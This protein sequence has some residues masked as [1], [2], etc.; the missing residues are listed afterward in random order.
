MSKIKREIEE[1]QSHSPD[2]KRRRENLSKARSSQQKHRNILG[3]D[4]SIGSRMQFN[5]YES[6]NTAIRSNQ[7]MRDTINHHDVDAYSSQISMGQSLTSKSMFKEIAKNSSRSQ[8]K[9]S[10]NYKPQESSQALIIQDTEGQPMANSKQRIFSAYQKR[11]N[12][13]IERNSNDQKIMRQ[14][15]GA[16]TIKKLQVD[17]RTRNTSYGGYSQIYDLLKDSCY[18]MKKSSA[19]VKIKF[20]DYCQKTCINRKIKLGDLGMGQNAATELSQII[21]VNQNIAH[22][23]LKKNLLGDEGVKILIK[24]ISKS[25]NIVHLD[26]SSNQ[27]THKGAKKI[28]T[29]LLPNCSLISLKLGSIDG[30]NKNK[31]GQKGVQHLIPLLQHSKFLQF[32]DLRSNI[33]SDNGIV[34]LCDA[35]FQNKTLVSLNLG[36]NEITSYGMERLKDALLTTVLNEL[37]LTGNPLGNQGI[38]YLGQYMSHADCN[39]VRLNISECRFQSPGSILLFQAVRKCSSLKH[40][41]L[42]KNDLKSRNSSYLTTGIYHGLT[43]LS[44]IRCNLG[45]DE[46]ISVAEGLSRSRQLKA[47]ILQYNSLSDEA[48]KTLAEAL[49]KPTVNIEHLD[50]SHNKIN[51]A[52]GELIAISLGQ[53]SSLSKLNLKSNNLKETTGSLFAKSVKQNSQ[54]QFLDLSKNSVP[55]NFIED[56][57]QQLQVNLIRA[58]KNKIPQYK[59]EVVQLKLEQENGYRKTQDD[60]VNCNKNKKQILEDIEKKKLLLIEQRVGEEER[61]FDIEVEKQRA[62]ILQ[63]EGQIQEVQKWIKKF[64]DAQEEHEENLKDYKMAIFRKKKEYKV[65]MTKLTQELESQDFFNEELKKKYNSMKQEYKLYSGNTDLLSPTTADEQVFDF[66]DKL[67]KFEKTS[68]NGDNKNRKSSKKAKSGLQKKTKQ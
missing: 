33:L 6:P 68:K 25:K 61:F 40:L 31:V 66:D 30:V 32:L 9:Q 11:S 44:M 3:F 20:K 22:I 54:I 37:D 5:D 43:Y 8:K 59:T 24:A 48:A 14:L 29:S 64:Q 26:L 15:Q 63:K 51:D 16:Q 23:D 56:I 42:D 45:D 50:L 34:T 21:A 18:S 12:T 13:K 19:V 65:E 47:L 60:I 58:A 55:V 2:R 57:E 35:L 4:Q 62:L 10:R 28:F 46:G 49:A 41:I 27:I 36:S 17:R 7:G 39:L 38:D 67:E 53:N 1:R 52:G